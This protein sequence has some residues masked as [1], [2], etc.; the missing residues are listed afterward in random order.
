[1]KLSKKMK[2][3]S[4]AACIGLSTILASC[5]LNS[6]KSKQINLAYV[7]WDTEV[8]STNVIGK[9]L[10]NMG[11][12]VQLTPLDNAIMW[13]AVS[14]GEADAMVGGWLPN[15][16]AAQYKKYKND[17]DDLGP[18]LKGAKIGLVVPKYMKENS[19]EDLKM[20]ANSTI[21][22]IEPGAGVVA[23]AEKAL[24]SYDNLTSWNVK[25]ASSGAMTIELG[26]AIKNKKDI[27]ITGWSPHWM[28]QKYDLKYLKDPKGVFG[29]EESIHTFARKSLKED[30]P[31]AYKVLDR[32]NW[33]TKDIEET[34]LKISEGEDP[35]DVAEEWI[36]K[37]PEKVASWTKGI[38][39]K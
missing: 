18:N 11:Y 24:K 12:D 19:I 31:D 1:M 33:S 21:T 22:G 27:V 8:A 26:K 30:K 36:K 16:H 39:E 32:F 2:A 35:E 6:V 9:V 5:D 17:L 7:E 34:M 14:K 23:T 37:N 13:E 20:Q 15:T 38:D 29:K 3:I 25:T 28:F 10:E 4:L